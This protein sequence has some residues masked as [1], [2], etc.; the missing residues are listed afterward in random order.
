SQN[1]WPSLA[2]DL[3]AVNGLA[4]PMF[5]AGFYY[6]TFMWP[7]SFWEKVYEPLIRRAA[8]LG[9]AARE[10]DPDKYERSH[11]F[12]D[13]LVVGSG[14]AGLTA[15]LAAARSG[16]RV[17]LCEQDFR[18]GGH[19]LASREEIDGK[20]ALDWVAEVEQELAAESKVRVLRRTTVFGLFDHGVCGALERVS[21]HLAEP[22]PFTV[23]Q[24][25]WK[26]VARRIIVAAGAIER[27]IVFPNNDRP[28]IMMASAV[29]SYIERFAV[30]PGRRAVVFMADDSGWPAVE[31]LQRAGASIAAVVDSRMEAPASAHR[32]V[33]VPVFTGA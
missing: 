11:L 10:P 7:A 19:L 18:L 13:V 2:F 3:M 9:R 17:V 27:P 23:R 20:T 4:A 31:A 24:R 22:P 5:P 28:G 21:D 32:T 12:C 33:D 8:G 16:A 1:R 15:A 25:Y 26:I 30:L 29:R 14:P 6:K